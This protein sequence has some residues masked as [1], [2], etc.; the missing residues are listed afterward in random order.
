MDYTLEIEIDLPRTEVVKKFEDPNNLKC[1]Q[2]GLLSFKPLT[3]T[4]GEEGAT[5][6]YRFTMGKR[7]IEM[8]ETI[9]KNNL[10]QEYHATYDAKGVH[11]IQENFFT[12]ISNNRT[13]WVSHSIFKFSGFMKIIGFTMPGSFKKQSLQYMQDF[14]AFAEDGKTVNHEKEEKIKNK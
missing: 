14:K 12:E 7:E 1:W 2:R 5:N 3:G 13:K 4:M 11:N 9:I 8:T 6:A 10:P